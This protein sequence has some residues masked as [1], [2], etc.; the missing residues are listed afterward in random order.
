MA[1]VYVV[2]NHL[3]Y[4]PDQGEL[5]PR[6]NISSAERFGK[7]RFILNPRC[8]TQRPE[9]VVAK[10][11]LIL[12]GYTDEDYLLPIGNPALIGW[13]VALA[14]AHNEG[15]V[16]MLVWSGKDRNYAEVSCLLPVRHARV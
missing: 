16:R 2:Q 8:N 12:A 7:L 3:R 6:Y 4:D 1:N 13:A 9:E 5:V 14:A 15:R 11:D 10:M